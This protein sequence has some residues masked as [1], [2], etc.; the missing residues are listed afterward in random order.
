MSHCG[1][2]GGVGQSCFNVLKIL[3]VK[4]L[5]SLSHV[6]MCLSSFCYIFNLDVKGAVSN[7]K[8]EV[9]I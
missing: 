5:M 3:K 2:L 9:C 4:H 6:A 8:C 1:A 7:F